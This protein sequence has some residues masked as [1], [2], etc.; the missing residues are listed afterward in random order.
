MLKGFLGVKGEDNAVV[1]DIG[2]KLEAY[3]DKEK[4]RWIF[5]DDDPAAEDPS[6]G[7]P[8]TAAELSK[9]PA[10]E[11]K[12]ATPPGLEPGTTEP[13]SAVLPITPGGSVS[14]TAL[15]LRAKWVPRQDSTRASSIDHRVG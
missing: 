12:K 7:P 8:P 4:K 11:E 9:T 14:S 6:A 1:A 2:G 15:F 13:K 3:Y 5:P 10:K